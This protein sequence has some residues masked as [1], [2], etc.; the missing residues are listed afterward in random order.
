VFKNFNTIEE[1]RATDPK[2]DLF[3]SVVDS[4]RGGP[5]HILIHV[6]AGQLTYLSVRSSPLFPPMHPCSTLSCW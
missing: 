6:A 2:K 1:F 5:L 3:N 4:V